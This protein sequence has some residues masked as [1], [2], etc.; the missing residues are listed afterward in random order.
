MAITITGSFEGEKE[1]RGHAPIFLVEFPSLGRFFAT[2]EPGFTGNWLADQGLTAS[3]TVDTDLEILADDTQ[4]TYSTILHKLSNNGIGG[5]RYELDDQ[6]FARTGDGFVSLLNQNFLNIDLEDEVLENVVARI[7]LGFN[8]LLR[9]DY[10]SVFKGVIDS[11]KANLER[12]SLRLADDTQRNIVPVP[13]QI[14]N[15]FRPR[16]FDQGKAFPIVLGCAEDVPMVQLVGDAS[17]FLGVNLLTTDTE[18]FYFN[19]TTRFPDT[20]TVRVTNSAVNYTVTYDGVTVE[21]VGQTTFGRLALTSAPSTNTDTGATVTL[22]SHPKKYVVSFAGQNIRRI[23]KDTGAAPAGA[24]TW[25]NEAIDP[26]GGDHRRITVV[27]LPNATTDG[28]SMTATIASEARGENLVF[29]GNFHNNATGWTVGTGAFDRFL[30]ASTF[31]HVGRIRTLAAQTLQTDVHQDITVEAG[32]KYRLTFTARNSDLVFMALNIGT[33]SSSSKYYQFGNIDG[34]TE[35][36]FDLVFLPD[37]TTLRLTMIGDNGASGSA[38]EGYFDQFDLYK[39]STENPSTQIEHLIKTHMPQVDPDPASF[40]EAFS[41]WDDSSDR[42]SG[43]LQQTEEQQALLGRIAQQFRAKT[44]LNEEGNQILRVFNQSRVPERTLTKDDI[45][46]GSMEVME[47]PLSEINTHYYV[48][49]GRVPETPVPEKPLGGRAAFAGVHTATPQQTSHPTVS[50]NTLCSDAKGKFR[51]ESTLEVFADLIPDSKTAE[52]LLEYLVRRGTHQRLRLEFRSWLRMVDIEVADFIKVQHPLISSLKTYEV[53]EKELLP[54][55]C[56]TRWVVEEI[57][58]FRFGSFT[59]K[60]EAPRSLVKATVNTEGWEPPAPGEPLDGD[61]IAGNQFNG[62]VEEWEP[63]H[64]SNSLFDLQQWDSTDALT[65]ELYGAMSTMD[66]NS[67]EAY[68]A[69]SDK[70]GMAM[71]PNAHNST[72]NGTESVPLVTPLQSKV[73]AIDT[74]LDLTINKNEFATNNS[75]IRLQPAFGSSRGEFIRVQSHNETFPN[76]SP[77]LAEQYEFDTMRWSALVNI[78]RRFSLRIFVKLNN[79]STDYPIWQGYDQDLVGTPITRIPYAIYYNSTTD[80]FEF[81]VANNIPGV[82]STIGANVASLTQK[83]QA[84]SLG[85]PSAGTWYQIVATYD[86]GTTTATIKANAGIEDSAV[87]TPDFTTGISRAGLIGGWSLTSDGSDMT[88]DPLVSRIKRVTLDG[89]VAAW[90]LWGRVITSAEA[91]TLYG[92]GTPYRFDSI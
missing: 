44:F 43:L 62:C 73:Y 6:G 22:E 58:P 90:A 82:G 13:A 26:T 61:L 20:G 75:A 21:T 91:T 66:T 25:K 33:P 16:A 64:P 12:F 5:L 69:T 27:D 47:S 67:F 7:M 46:K 19:P 56:E 1:Q 89:W 40:A 36:L 79:K 52:N 50:L 3:T 15:D 24:P 71:F 85:S 53:L 63:D 51:K 37:E 76:S 23:R 49:Y 70:K 83:V 41:I 74:A 42:V 87:I 39:F 72:A 32:V 34:T 17:S 30:P 60:W 48:Y 92:A 18:L 78:E 86:P 4:P 57:A 38:Q 80:R 81:A 77:E 28:E 35:Q 31:D 14:G 2:K 84:T 10:I 54:N 55:G 11:S 68:R 65:S 88:V 9:S 8:G 45:A 59:E 29:N